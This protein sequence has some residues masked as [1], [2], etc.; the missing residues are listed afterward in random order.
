MQKFYKKFYFIM[1]NYNDP[2]NRPHS[3]ND[4]TNLVS[5]KFEVLE[6]KRSHPLDICPSHRLLFD[7]DNRFGGDEPLIYITNVLDKYNDVESFCNYVGKL[8]KSQTNREKVQ[9]RKVTL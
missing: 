4:L 8:K 6:D 5:K 1:R 2:S 9:L 7:K 3:N